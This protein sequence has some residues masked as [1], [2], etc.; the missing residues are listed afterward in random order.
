MVALLNGGSA[1]W[2]AWRLSPSCIKVRCVALTCRR[3][4]GSRGKARSESDL[5]GG[6]WWRGI[7]SRTTLR[8]GSHSL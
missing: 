8:P 7:P 5:D 1:K 3:A 4:S 6:G 2:A